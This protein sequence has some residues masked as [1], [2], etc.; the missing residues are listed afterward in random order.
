MARSLFSYSCCL[1]WGWI[2]QWKK[3]R[4]GSPPTVRS[5]LVPLCVNWDAVR[6]PGVNCRKQKSLIGFNGSTDTVTAEQTSPLL[7]GPAHCA[8]RG[9]TNVVTSGREGQLYP[10]LLLRWMSDAAAAE[11]SPARQNQRWSEDTKCGAVAS[12]VMWYLFI[13]LSKV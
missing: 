10:S 5:A 6:L 1:G 13:C 12:N 9:G 3:H 8:Q 2:R 11:R 4:V 7:R